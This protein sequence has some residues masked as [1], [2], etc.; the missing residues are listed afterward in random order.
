MY[1][2]ILKQTII[3]VQKLFWRQNSSITDGGAALQNS[4]SES[5][6]LELCKPFG[7]TGFQHFLHDLVGAI[8]VTREVDK[9]VFHTVNL[10]GMV[11]MNSA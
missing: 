2:D 11:G 10:V 4:Y 3:S 6:V 1:R 8:R 7:Y 5:K 9:D